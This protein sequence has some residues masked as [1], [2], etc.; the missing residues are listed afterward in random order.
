MSLT[1]KNFEKKVEKVKLGK[2]ATFVDIKSAKTKR[3]AA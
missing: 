2:V 1:K 3:L